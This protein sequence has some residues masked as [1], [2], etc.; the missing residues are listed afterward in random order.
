MGGRRAGGDSVNSHNN[1]QLPNSPSPMTKWLAPVSGFLRIPDQ[2]G[3]TCFWQ[4]LFLAPVSGILNGDWKP[5][6]VRPNGVSCP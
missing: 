6:L 4:H 1:N 3:G 2:K 5:W